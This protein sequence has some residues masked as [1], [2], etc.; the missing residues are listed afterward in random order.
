MGIIFSLDNGYSEGIFFGI[1][2]GLFTGFFTTMMVHYKHNK[3]IKRLGYEISEKTYN[4]VQAR[5]IDLNVPYNK[6]YDFCLKFIHL[7]KKGRIK[8]EDRKKGIINV[9]IGIKLQ[10]NPCVIIFK[11]EKID[12][13]KTHIEIISKPFIPTWIFDVGDSLEYVT[14]ILNFLN[15]QE[16]RFLATKKSVPSR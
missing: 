7:L 9:R 12:N 10:R 3:V 16:N 6:A 1:I 14:L 2:C 13:N 5:Q 8:N 11:L 15:R 4:S